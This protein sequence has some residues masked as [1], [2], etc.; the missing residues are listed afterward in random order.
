MIFIYFYMLLI[1]LLYFYNI[2]IFQ[3]HNVEK[4]PR[5]KKSLDNL[6][7]EGTFS[8]VTEAHQIY[9]AHEATR[10]DS[11]PPPARPRSK[12]VRLSEGSD[13]EKRQSSHEYC[14]YD[15]NLKN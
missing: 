5:Q 13:F 4:A 3:P 10:K 15:Q 7:P 11:K 9:S 2:N 8:D 12:N 1:V 6:K 14:H